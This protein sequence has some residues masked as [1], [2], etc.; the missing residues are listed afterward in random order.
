MMTAK[1]QGFLF[2]VHKPIVD[3]VVALYVF[4]TKML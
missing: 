4:H 3:V 2:V 1:T